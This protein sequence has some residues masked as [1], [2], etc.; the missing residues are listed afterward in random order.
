FAAFHKFHEEVTK[1]WRVWVNLTP[2][3]DPA[4]VPALGAWL[5]LAPADRTTA[6]VLARVLE[7]DGRK[8]EARPVLDL[9][10]AFHP[11]DAK[12]WGQTVR[13][14]ADRQEEEAT[15]RALV[16]RFPDEPKYALSLGEVRV[17]RGDGDGAKA[18]LA[19]LAEKGPGPVRGAAHYQLARAC[20]L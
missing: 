1:A 7:L 16:R 12:L 9:A 6:S 3:Q 17:R 14:A 8:A 15:Y 19:P 20:L 13:L 2:T 4:D 18:V 10:P 5:A 11:H